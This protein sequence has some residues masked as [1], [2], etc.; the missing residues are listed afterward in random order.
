MNKEEFDQRLEVIRRLKFN[1]IHLDEAIDKLYSGTLPP[2]SLVLTIDDGFYSTYKLAAPSLRRFGFPATVYATTYYVQ[3]PNPVFRLVVQYMFWKTTKK[4][5]RIENSRWHEN[6]DVDLSNQ[7]QVAKVMWACIDHGER[8][9]NE[10]QRVAISTELG[11]LLD[12]PYKAIS[13]SRMF[14]LMTP[15]EL[16]SLSTSGFCIELHTHR[17]V[18]SQESKDD[19]QREIR[20]NREALLAATGR[21]PTHFCY[22]SGHWAVQQWDWL[23]EMHVKSSTTCLPGLND[24]NSPRHALTRFLDGSNIHKL[25]FEAELSGV[26][27]LARKLR[28]QA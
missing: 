14:H 20:D 7:A 18:F 19:A 26:L 1:V 16:R 17:H 23:T 8:S 24:Q 3:H 11:Q 5:L 13:E 28:R 25:E 15:K 9:C 2:D 4:Q 22:P 12:V 21:E 10:D 27:E 6:R